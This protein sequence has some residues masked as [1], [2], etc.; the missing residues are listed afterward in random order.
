MGLSSLG[1]KRVDLVIVNKMFMHV[2]DVENQNLFSYNLH[3]FLA[4]GSISRPKRS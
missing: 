2:Y 3:V 1:N 4:W